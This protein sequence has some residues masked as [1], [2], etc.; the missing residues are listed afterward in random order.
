M[1]KHTNI[2]I[3]LVAAALAPVA[4]AGAILAPTAS[5]GPASP[6]AGFGQDSRA[7][8]S[9][10]Y[11]RG[12]DVRN[13]SGRPI[14]LVSLSGGGRFEGRPNIGDVIQPGGSQRFELQYQLLG[15]ETDTVN[16]QTTDGSG[17]Y[18]SG[19]MRV[20]GGGRSYSLCWAAGGFECSPLTNPGGSQGRWN[21]D[22]NTL[23]FLDAPGTEHTIAANDAQ[24][25]AEI[26]KQMCDEGGATCTFTP[27][28]EE[29]ALS[30]RDVPSGSAFTSPDRD[31]TDTVILADDTARSSD[32]LGGSITAS[33]G[34]SKIVNA[35]ID[36]TF[37]HTWTKSQ[38]YSQT[39]TIRDIPRN[40]TVWVTH[41]AP[42][43]RDT[44][45]FTVKLGNTTW[46]LTDVHFDSPE[47]A[48]N[49]GNYGGGLYTIH[50]SFGDPVGGTLVDASPGSKLQDS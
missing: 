34:L 1:K 25:Q 11:S 20:D 43:L 23:T 39:V 38:S 32:S 12:F 28:K 36:A 7:G 22:A 45:D 27:T 14:K 31:H 35:A 24:K 49:G 30:D 50:Q 2:N 37:G 44:G 21:A 13:E 3:K 47:D 46:H 16:Y 26:L 19:S 29:H 9:V 42:V 5:A 4:A 10:R 40:A 15:D 6:A 48:Q 8:Q 33:A 41:R 17:G 18:F